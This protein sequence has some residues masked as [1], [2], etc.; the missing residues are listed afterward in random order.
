MKRITVG[1][2]LSVCVSNDAVCTNHVDQDCIAFSFGSRRDEI[3][4]FL[5]EDLGVDR[6][7]WCEQALEEHVRDVIGPPFLTSVIP[8]EG[9]T[10][11][12]FQA[13][14]VLEEQKCVVNRMIAS[15]V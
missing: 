7:A 4:F 13:A 1:E 11:Q 10:W 2:I 6:L 12:G 9:D 5:F 8:V 3:R 14:T 15:K